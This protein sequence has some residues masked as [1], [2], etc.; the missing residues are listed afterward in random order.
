MLVTV[1]TAGICGVRAFTRRCSGI[2]VLLQFLHSR[3]PPR[4][5]LTLTLTPSSVYPALHGYIA[6]V[7]THIPQQR[8]GRQWIYRLQRHRHRQG[9]CAN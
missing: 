7:F 5:T 6:P 9:R 3:I 1:A 8:R 4:G 2:H